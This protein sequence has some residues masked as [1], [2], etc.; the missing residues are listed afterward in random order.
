MSLEPVGGISPNL[1]KFMI[2]AS[3]RVDRILVTLILISKSQEDLN[4]Y[5]KFLLKMINFKS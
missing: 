3:L 2:R 1:H 4:N 5:A